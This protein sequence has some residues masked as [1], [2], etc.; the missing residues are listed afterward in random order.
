MTES[1]GETAARAHPLAVV[2]DHHTGQWTG[3]GAIALGLFGAGAV[4]GTPALALAAVVPLALAGH[5]ALAALPPTEGADGDPVVTVERDLQTPDPEPGDP[6]VVT[7]TVRNEGEHLLPDVRVQDGV[8]A[9]LP[10]V[11]GTPR[12][13][14]FLV[15]GGETTFSYVVRAQRGEFRWGPA[16]VTLGDASGSVER[17]VTVDAPTTLECPLPPLGNPRQ[18][19]PLRDLTT[20]Y[21]GRVETHTGGEGI[22]FFATREYRHSDPLSRV[23]WRRFARTGE[24]AT[25]EFRQERIARVMLVVDTRRAAYVAPAGATRHAVDRA[26]EAAH[27]IFVGLL[28][29]SNPVGLTAFGPTDR[30]CWLAPGSGAAHRARGRDLLS[31]HPAFDREPPEREQYASF[32]PERRAELRRRQIDRLHERLLP[33]T[34]VVL[35]SPCCDDYAPRIARRLETYGRPVTVLSP[36]PT[37]MDSSASGLAGVERTDRLAD[38][39]ARGVRVVDWGPDESLVSALAAARRRSR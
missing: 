1:D 11:A 23:D 13:G 18:H 7:V 32:E 15:A 12:H 10:V 5:G 22:E 27:R 39:R 25:T 21:P 19:L 31:T 24:L 36:D 37:S 34:Q 8:P 9:D 29:T 38:L 14:D 17:E 4:T 33:D 35:L 20:N 6:T 16:T 30:E 2:A 26:V 28:D 3:V